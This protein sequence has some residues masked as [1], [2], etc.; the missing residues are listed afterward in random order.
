ME[1]IPNKRRIISMNVNGLNIPNKRR[2]L[3]DHF[4]RSKADIILLQETHAS[5]ATE[6]IWR[7]EW[8]G[9]AYFCNG[10][11][12]SKGVAVL[13][14]RDVQAEVF[15]QRSE[16]TGRILCMD[17]RLNDTIFTLCSIYAP[18]QDR[19]G[20]Q[21]ENLGNVDNFLEDL[22][23]TNIIVWGDF[24]CFLNPS[25]DRN[26]WCGV[27]THTE[28][29]RARI[30]SF[31]EN[32]SLCD[33]WRQRNPNKTGFTFRRG[34]YASRLDYVMIS[35]HLSEL[36]CS[37]TSKMLAHSDPAMVLVSIKPS[38]ITKG[39]GLWTPTQYGNGSSS[40]SRGL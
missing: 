5:A 22:T 19:A 26:S 33:I 2:I 12:S 4:R 13:V 30:L 34:S 32:W 29:Y 9:Q 35:N 28:P 20:E 36:V 23:S 21:L 18:T 15:D 17:I 39:P 37:S 10:S 16:D 14:S 40:R 31:L 11:Q 8:G 6:K 7:R 24:N 27:P 25:L 38:L 3:F 1:G